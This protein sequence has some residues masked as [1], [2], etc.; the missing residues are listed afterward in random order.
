M[1]TLVWSDQTLGFRVELTTIRG[2]KLLST[3][4]MW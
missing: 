1:A 3:S 4:P 2:E